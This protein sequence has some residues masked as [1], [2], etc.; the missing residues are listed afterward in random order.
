VFIVFNIVV[1]NYKN[2]LDSDSYKKRPYRLAAV[3]FR[4]IAPV[5]FWI[6]VVSCQL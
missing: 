2:T 1:L 5:R 6:T 3:S 4:K